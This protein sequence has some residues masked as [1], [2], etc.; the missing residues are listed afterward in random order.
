MTPFTVNYTGDYLDERGAL[1]VPD[2]ALD[3]YAPHA[4]IR[5]GF[6]ADQSASPGNTTYWDRLYSLEIEPHHVAQSDAI[7]I[8]RPWV[9]ASAFADGAER[10]TVVEQQITHVV[11]MGVEEVMGEPPERRIPRAARII[12]TIAAYQ[13]EEGG[14]AERSGQPFSGR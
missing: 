10:L 6:L 5:Q 13:R 7:V 8:F 4:F 14:D 12:P 9:K 3:L 11:R 1:A 2:I